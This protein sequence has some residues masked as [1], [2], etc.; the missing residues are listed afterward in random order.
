[1]SFVCWRASRKLVVVTYRKRLSF[2]GE[3]CCMGL[4]PSRTSKPRG[5]PLR[6]GELVHD[7][8]LRRRDLLQHHLRHAVSLVHREI[9]VRVVEQDD[10]DGTP[11]VVVH[12]SSARVDGV[13]PGKARPRGD[14]G[15]GPV[16]DRDGNV[17]L[18]HP[19][20]PGGDDALVGTVQVVASRSV[21]PPLRHDSVL[22][23][24]LHLEYHVAPSVGRRRLDLLHLHWASEGNVAGVGGGHKG[25]G[26]VFVVVPVSPRSRGR[27]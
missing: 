19:L 3:G 4:V 24:L 11:V 21:G 25:P 2:L 10:A 7:G 12:D 14:P 8:D 13:L 6:V 16:R 9:H 22:R 5:A 27:R 15:V 1:M 17:R 20:A 26:A 18:D 23:Q